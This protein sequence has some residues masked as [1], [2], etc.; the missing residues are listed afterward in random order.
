M[1]LGWWH[2]LI[3]LAVFVLLFGAGRVSGLMGDIARGLRSFNKAMAEGEEIDGRPIAKE[4]A[5]SARKD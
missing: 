5:N 3:V 1:G 2:I 4:H